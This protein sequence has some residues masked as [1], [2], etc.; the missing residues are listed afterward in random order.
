[1]KDICIFYGAYYE[2]QQYS[3]CITNLH[4]V[5]I[6]KLTGNEFNFCPWIIFWHPITWFRAFLLKFENVTWLFPTSTY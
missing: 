6:Y 3:T 5:F 4:A 2:Y 1:L